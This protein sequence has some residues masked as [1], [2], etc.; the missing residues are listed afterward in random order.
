MMQEACH[1]KK[2]EG[3]QEKKQTLQREKKTLGKI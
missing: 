2:K 3:S 1:K